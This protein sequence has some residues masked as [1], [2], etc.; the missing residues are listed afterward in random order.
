MI[1]RQGHLYQHGYSRV[2]AMESGDRV[3]VR[4]VLVE[5]PW[6]GPPLRVKAEWLKP[7]PM[8]Y[9]QGSVPA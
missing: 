9:H 3:T 5:S 7:L 2:I 6:L 4:E 8:K 1:A